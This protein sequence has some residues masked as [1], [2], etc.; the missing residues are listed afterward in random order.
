MIADG[1]VAILRAGTNRSGIASSFRSVDGL[2]HI[3]AS[4]E[5]SFHGFATAIVDGLRNRGDR[6]AVGNIV[7]IE[8][9]D[10]PTRATR[11]RNS[12]LDLGR[13]QRGFGVNMPNWKDALDVELDDVF[14]PPEPESRN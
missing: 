3:A 11:P 13:L 10:F 7:A 1:V 6:L 8:T 4:G 5:T 9:R 12:R 14:A 2:V